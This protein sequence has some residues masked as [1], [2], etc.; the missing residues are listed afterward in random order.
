MHLLGGIFAHWHQDLGVLLRLFVAAVLSGALGWQRESAGKAAGVRT[1]M[2]VGIGAAFFMCIVAMEI[3][4]FP[5]TPGIVHFD[6]IRI[7]Q[8][9]VAGVS[10]LGA[11]TIFVDKSRHHV[12]GLTTAASIWTTTAVGLSVGLGRYLLATGATILILVVLG[13]VRFIEPKEGR[14]TGNPDEEE[15]EERREANRKLPNPGAM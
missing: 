12:R 4:T 6:P 2:L 9:V 15:L 13:A 8:A 7:L 10:F 11:G 14:E 3:E 1:H 5:G